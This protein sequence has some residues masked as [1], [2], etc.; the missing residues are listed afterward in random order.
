MKSTIF[1]DITPCSQLSVNRRFGGTYSLHLQGRK[2]SWARKTSVKACGK[3]NFFD[4]EDVGDMFLRNVGWHSTDYTALHPRKWYS[5]ML[6]LILRKQNILQSSVSEED[7]AVGFCNHESEPSVSTK[8]NSNFLTSLEIITCSTSCIYLLSCK[9]SL[10][11]NL[12]SARQHWLIE[13]PPGAIRFQG[14]HILQFLFFYD[15]LV[16]E[17]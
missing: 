4:P 9:R 17:N 14:L 12:R 5:S 13:L 11:C 3:Q 6:K 15:I 1:W 7:P 2:I 10:V 16:N 8:E